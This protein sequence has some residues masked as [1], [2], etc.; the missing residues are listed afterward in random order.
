MWIFLEMGSGKKISVLLSLLITTG[1]CVRAV[2][3]GKTDDGCPDALPL[4]SRRLCWQ[5]FTV[6]ISTCSEHCSSP[7][8]IVRTPC[9]DPALVSVYGHYITCQYRQIPH[10]IVVKEAGAC[11]QDQLE[12]LRKASHRLK[13]VSVKG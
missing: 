11:N 3:A 10:M 5:P 13:K 4:A 2:C 12:Q 7:F 9:K 1:W 6:L 8:T